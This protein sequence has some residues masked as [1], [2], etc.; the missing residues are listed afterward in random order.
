[1]S[2]SNHDDSTAL[3]PH[4]ELLLNFVPPPRQ[5]ESAKPILSTELD[6]SPHTIVDTTEALSKLLTILKQVEE[7]AIDIEIV[8]TRT[9]REYMCSTLVI[10]TRVEDYIVD[11]M[12]LK[13]HLPTLNEVFV[14]TRVLKVMIRSMG[15]KLECLQR[16]CGLYVVNLFD[17]EVANNEIQLSQLPD[18][19]GSARSSLYK[20][21]RD[22]CHVIV[23]KHSF[24]KLDMCSRPLS[25]AA[26]NCLRESTHYLLHLYDVLRNKLLSLKKR[27]KKCPGGALGQVY[28]TSREHC[29]VFHDPNRYI[30]QDDT[31]E[32]TLKQHVGRGVGLNP[33]QL[34]CYQHLHDWRWEL[35]ETNN[36]SLQ[37]VLPIYVLLKI[38]KNLPRNRHD[39]EQL[40]PDSLI[41]ARFEEHVEEILA[42]VSEAV[43]LYPLDPKQQAII[44][45][46]RKLNNELDKTTVNEDLRDDDNNHPGSSFKSLSEASYR[47][48]EMKRTRGKD[49]GEKRFGKVAGSGGGGWRWG[50]DDITDTKKRRVSST[51][52]YGTLEEMGLLKEETF[53]VKGPLKNPHASN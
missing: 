22:N 12:A 20:L 27:K 7:F 53:R 13:E 16:D 21:L 36:E 18:P 17:V 45:L 24:K 46:R 28:E 48:E 43:A 51:E 30:L 49:V 5:L 25:E 42:F 11:V 10:S 31:Y 41:P 38:G 32:K 52:L 14:N 47:I 1:M 35:A 19:V 50:H 40:F 8:P 9:F 29:S 2:C 39:L 4:K 34:R 37:N 6:R 44:E 3:H 23:D 33:Q 15:D 26:I